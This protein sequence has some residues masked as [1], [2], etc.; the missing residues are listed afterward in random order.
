MSRRMIEV[1]DEKTPE[2]RDGAGKNK[3][4]LTFTERLKRSLFPSWQHPNE[5]EELPLPSDPPNTAESSP[6]HEGPPSPTSPAKSLVTFSSTHFAGRPPRTRSAGKQPTITTN[7]GKETKSK[8][9]HSDGQQT[10]QH[11]H[12]SIPLFQ[13]F[14]LSPE[15]VNPLVPRMNEDLGGKANSNENKSV[16]QYLGASLEQPRPTS[17]SPGSRSATTG[18]Q[19]RLQ[20]LHDAEAD[21][22]DDAADDDDIMPDR[23]GQPPNPLGGWQSLKR[24]GSEVMRFSRN[25]GQVAEAA[26][27]MGVRRRQNN[28]ISYSQYSF[29]DQHDVAMQNAE[30]MWLQKRA[31]QL[32]AEESTPASGIVVPSTEPAGPSD[33]TRAE[34]SNGVREAV[35]VEEG[36]KVHNLAVGEK[37]QQELCNSPLTSKCDRPVSKTAG[38]LQEYRQHFERH[39]LNLK[40]NYFSKIKPRIDTGLGDIRVPARKEVIATTVLKKATK[41][42]G[43]KGPPAGPAADHSN[44]EPICYSKVKPRIDTGLGKIRVPARKE[45][46]ATTVLKKATKADGNKG[47]PAEPAADNS[48]NEPICS[49]KGKPRIDTGLGVMQVL[50]ALL[51][52][53]QAIDIPVGRMPVTDV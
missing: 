48:N 28:A 49:A 5:D 38:D 29:Y 52:R 51:A 33:Q 34:M 43:N 15:S 50:G 36:T 11:Y 39:Y 23:R 10:A 19:K 20:Q 44:N 14:Q 16:R 7:K 8:G 26:E 40:E 4:R 35:S 41:A 30:I 53:K 45:V 21:A 9:N 13:Q 17:P 27:P 3:F 1:G 42:G 2:R 47:P 24:L 22:T 12:D 46:I 37:P 32:L 6:S 18:S 25:L 31:D